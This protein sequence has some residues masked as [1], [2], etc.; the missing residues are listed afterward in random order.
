MTEAP[1]FSQIKAQVT[2][3]RQKVPNAR[4]IGNRAAGR[5]PGERL[6]QDGQDTLRIEQCDSPLHMRMALQDDDGSAITVLIS[7]M[8]ERGLRDDILVRLA[9]RRLFPI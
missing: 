3:I 6:K 1:T 8:E 5:R 9:M 2:A 4:V 7:S